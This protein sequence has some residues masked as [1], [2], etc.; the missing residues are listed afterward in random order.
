MNERM[1]LAK[2][3]GSPSQMQK[4]SSPTASKIQPADEQQQSLEYE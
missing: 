1:I 2:S 4:M 3:L